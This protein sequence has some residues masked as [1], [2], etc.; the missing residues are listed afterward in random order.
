MAIFLI[1]P[2]EKIYYSDIFL[3]SDHLFIGEMMGERGKA[4]EAE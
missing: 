2:Q 3:V 4:W 1:D